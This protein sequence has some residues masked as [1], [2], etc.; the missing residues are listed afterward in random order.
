MMVAEDVDENLQLAAEKVKKAAEMG[1]DFVLL[2]EM[3][4]CPYRSDSFVKNQEP[5]GGPIWQALSDMAKEN[6][7]Y[8]IGGTMPESD[9]GELPKAAHDIQNDWQQVQKRSSVGQAKIYNTCFVFNPAG[10]Q[11]GRHRKMHLFDIDIRGGQRFCESDTFSAGNEV[12]VIDTKYGKIGVEICF[13]IRFQE[14]THLMALEGAGIVFVPAAFNMT[15]GPVHWDL[16]FRARAVDSQI[17]M[18]GC[19]AARDTKAAYVAYGHSLL[20]SPWGDILQEADEREQIILQEIDLSQIA[21]IR[22]QLPILSARRE[23][24]YQLTQNRN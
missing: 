6:H 15:T 4:C 8:L 13:D 11:I 24:V 20:V 21:D 17:F 7:I 19:S 18:T 16:H 22:A 5:A 10:L 1:A 2:P 9:R 3:F 14:L 12:T 23:D